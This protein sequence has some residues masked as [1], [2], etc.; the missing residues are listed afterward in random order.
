MLGVKLIK[1]YIDVHIFQDNNNN[2]YCNIK[3]TET[4]SQCV[5]LNVIYFRRIFRLMFPLI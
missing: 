4:C 3:Y 1:I 5:L 2:D